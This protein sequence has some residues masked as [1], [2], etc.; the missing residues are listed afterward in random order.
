MDKCNE[1]FKYFGI[2]VQI[3]QVGKLLIEIEVVTQI[4]IIFTEQQNNVA[5]AH[6]ERG[7]WLRA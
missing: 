5:R 2:W 1:L 3:T 4:D 6:V 7:V